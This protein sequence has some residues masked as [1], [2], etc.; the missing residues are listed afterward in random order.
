M[1]YFCLMQ[2]SNPF[3]ISGYHTPNEFCDRENETQRLREGILNGRNLTLISWRRMGKTGLIDHTFHLMNKEK[4]HSFFYVDLLPTLSLAD[5]IREFSKS[6]IGKLDSPSSK[7]IKKIG[8]LLSHLRPTITYD[9]LTG[10]P[11]ILFDFVKS[12]NEQNTLE[13]IFNY[14]DSQKNKIVIALDEFQQILKY[15]EQNT[16]AL[17]RSHIQK[18]KNI[19]FIFSGSRKHLLEAMFRDSGRP[20]YNSTEILFL[21]KIN[22]E[23]Y[24]NFIN[25][26]FKEGGTKITSEVIDQILEWCRYHTWFVQYVCNRLYSLS[27]DEIDVTILHQMM[28]TILEENE[29]GYYG[30]R[31]LITAFQWKVLNA[32]AVEKKLSEPNGKA[33]LTKYQLGAASSVSLAIEALL[34]KELIFRENEI[35]YVYDVF[36]ARWMERKY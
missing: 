20:F 14:L 19:S 16:E 9:N 13:Q 27:R 2:L 36:L 12:G 1:L 30:Y 22:S 32:I 11:S 31:N 4:D 29:P 6:V 35:F 24:C 21:E 5:F 3:L 17:L 7:I 25:K 18:S 10:E 34:D 8:T 26:K 15:P 33:F 23:E 28:V